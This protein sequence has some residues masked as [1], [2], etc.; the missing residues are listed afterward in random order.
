MS[1]R[2]KAIFSWTRWASS[3]DPPLALIELWAADCCVVGPEN[4]LFGAVEG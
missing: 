2:P 4:V 3:V 1:Q